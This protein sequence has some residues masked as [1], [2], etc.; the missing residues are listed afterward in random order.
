MKAKY[1]RVSLEWIKILATKKCMVAPKIV[2]N[3][4]KFVLALVYSH[5]V[6]NGL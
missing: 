3:D 4:F 5:A 6:R 2:K 1:H